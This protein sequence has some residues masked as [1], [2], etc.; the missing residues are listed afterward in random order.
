MNFENC[1]FKKAYEILGGNK[2]A[3]AKMK[4]K[5]RIELMKQT[6]YEVAE[7]A[8]LKALDVWCA[9]DYLKTYYAQT[10]DKSVYP[11]YVYAMRKLSTYQQNLVEKE[12]ELY[13]LRKRI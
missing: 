12:A 1:D 9:A 6:Q 11:Y 2:P 7:K 3:T 13:E 4:H 10:R 5:A 8:Y